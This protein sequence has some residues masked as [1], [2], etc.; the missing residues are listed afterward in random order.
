MSAAAALAGGVREVIESVVDE[1]DRPPSLVELLTILA[2]GVRTMPAGALTDAHPDEIVGLVERPPAADRSTGAVSEL[3]DNAFVVAA[4]AFGDWAEAGPPVPLAGLASALLATL[5]E[6]GPD[7]RDPADA[8]RLTAVTPELRRARARPRVGDVI[9]VPPG[10]LVVLLCRNRIGT[11]FGL[12]RGAFPA[13]A[14]PADLRTHATGTA[15]YSEERAIHSGRWRIVGHDEGLLD[16]FPGEPE[17]YHLP[18]PGTPSI[19][20]L[21]VIGEFGAAETAD[22]RLRDISEA[23]ARAVDLRGAYRQS[24]LYELFE[25]EL[26]RL[27]ARPSPPR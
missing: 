1:L 4:A 23:E 19:P 18:L 17:I 14:A 10:H 26:P 12:F 16:A 20:G 5:R 15:V 3:N 24:Y 11:A 9:A 6:V 8:A 2:D 7:L 25:M 21:P 13:Q 27:I 22:G